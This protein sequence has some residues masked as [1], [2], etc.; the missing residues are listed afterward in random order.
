VALSY[1]TE[2]CGKNAQEADHNHEGSRPKGQ[3][4]NTIELSDLNDSHA[5]PAKPDVDHG[6]QN[7]N[8]NHVAH[9]MHAF[10]TITMLSS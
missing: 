5:G 9:P 8:Y 3:D 7:A 2:Q 4:P 1:T 6:Y 10:R